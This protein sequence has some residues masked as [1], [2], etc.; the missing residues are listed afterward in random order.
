MNGSLWQSFHWPRRQR[1]TLAR[2]WPLRRRLDRCRVLLLLHWQPLFLHQ[3]GP[4]GVEVVA[5]RVALPLR[6]AMEV[7]AWFEAIRAVVDPG[8]THAVATRQVAAARA[9][10]LLEATLG[11]VVVVSKTLGA[12][13]WVVVAEAWPAA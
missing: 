9:V 3:T 10:V 6:G 12:A 13:M 11:V 7:M 8:R 5:P 2:N 4:S 1:Q